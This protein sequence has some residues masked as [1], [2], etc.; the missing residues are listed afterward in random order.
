MIIKIFRSQLVAF[1]GNIAMVFPMC[2]FF[3]WAYF[4]FTGQFFIPIL[5]AYKTVK[6][7]HPFES[8]A[9]IYGAVTGFF[10]FL[11]GLISCYFDNLN[12]YNK[13]SIRI[14]KHPFLNLFIKKS[15]L[16]KFSNYI[17]KNLGNFAGNIFLGIFLGSTATIGYFFGLPLDSL[18]VTFATGNFGMSLFELKSILSQEEILMTGLG[19]FLIGAMNFGISF[20]LALLVAMRSR[21]VTLKQG[22]MLFKILHSQFIRN[23][24]Q[25]ILPVG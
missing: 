17:D 24:F 6:E 25:F 21:N 16:E 15:W 22:R 8:P 11:V 18:H 19:I 1:A 10:L 7:L 3:H 5:T 23:P 4:K 20:G 13:I 9:I 2:Y 14:K 12:V